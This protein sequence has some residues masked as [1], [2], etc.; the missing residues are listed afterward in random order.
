MLNRV[1]TKT[2][3]VSL[4]QRLVAVLDPGLTHGGGRPVICSF[5][6]G[7]YGIP[8][9][10]LIVLEGSPP[11]GAV[12]VQCGWNQR[13]TEHRPYAY[14]ISSGGEIKRLP[15]KHIGVVN[16]LMELFDLNHGAF[17]EPRSFLLNATELGEVQPKTN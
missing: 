9:Y 12:L 8:A 1:E 3:T 7:A 5:V 15:Q 14:R 4:Y 17:V 2:G 6:P 13:V 16:N 11:K 10:C